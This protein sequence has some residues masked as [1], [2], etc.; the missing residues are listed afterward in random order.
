MRFVTLLLLFFTSIAHAQTVYNGNIHTFELQRAGTA[1]IPNVYKSK[2]NGHLTGAAAAW[3]TTSQA[4]IQLEKVKSED[5]EDGVVTE[6]NKGT[7]A[8]IHFFGGSDT[9]RVEA[10]FS[11]GNRGV[12]SIRSTN[13]VHQNNVFI[14]VSPSSGLIK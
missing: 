5:K 9:M 1:I 14:L 3:G 4:G 7:G 11:K 13:F 2:R 10:K 8:K 12:C 6:R